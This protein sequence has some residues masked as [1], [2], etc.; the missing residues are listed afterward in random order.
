[1]DELTVKR[2]KA[3]LAIVKELEKFFRAYPD[4][5]FGQALVNLDLVKPETYESYD[6]NDEV[7]FRYWQQEYN[8]EPMDLLK[9]LRAAIKKMTEG[10][11]GDGR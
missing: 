10:A 3:N 7:Y 5:R 2:Q 9:R 6:G 4:Q 11:S 1:M 8:T